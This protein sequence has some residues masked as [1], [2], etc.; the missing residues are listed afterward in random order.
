MVIAAES[1][2]VRIGGSARRRWPGNR[3]VPVRAAVG[4]TVIS[5]QAARSLAF[6]PGFV[7][8]QAPGIIGSAIAERLGDDR[9]VEL[10]AVLREGP[11]HAAVRVGQ[12]ADPVIASANGDLLTAARFGSA[13][14]DEN[15]AEIRRRP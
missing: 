11:E 2:T 6:C 13:E 9:P 12:H 4:G 8:G 7:D 3:D 5:Y 1:A 10:T 14:Q 15:L